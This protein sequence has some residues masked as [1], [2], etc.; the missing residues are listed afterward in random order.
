MGQDNEIRSREQINLELMHIYQRIGN[1]DAGILHSELDEIFQYK[2]VDNYFIFVK[3]SLFLYE[4]KY[5]KFWNTLSGKENW[6][7][8][9]PYAILLAKLQYEGAIATNSAYGARRQKINIYYTYLASTTTINTNRAIYLEKELIED[10]KECYEEEEGK[11]INLFRALIAQKNSKEQMIVALRKMFECYYNLQQDVQDVILL[12]LR[13]YYIADPSWVYQNFWNTVY[14]RESN[15]GY[16]IRELGEKDSSPF[17]VIQDK[18][19]REEEYHY[20][21]ECLRLLKQDVIIID[22]NFAEKVVQLLENH[23]IYNILASNDMFQNLK[24]RK[25]FDITNLSSFKG[26]L[27]GDLLSFGYCGKYEEYLHKIYKYRYIEKIKEE[28]NC[29]FSIV[30]PARNNAYTLKYTIQTILEQRNV[31]KDEFELVIS[32]NSDSGNNA[33]KNLVDSFDNPQIKYFRT[34]TELPLQRSFEFAYGMA[35]GKYI[36][37]VGSDDGF[38]PWSLETLKKM[39]KKYPD[40]NVIGWHRAFFQWSESKSNQSGKLIIPGIY[41]KEL[42][43]EKLYSGIATLKSQMKTNGKSIYAVP[44]LYINSAFK[45]KYL[46]EL[47]QNTGAVLDGYTQDIRMGIQSLLL[48]KTFLYLE[49]PLSIAGLSDASLGAKMVSEVKTD[50]DLTAK[51]NRE[52]VKGVGNVNISAEYPFLVLPST[53]GMFWSEI[54]KLLES[55]SCMEYLMELFTDHDFKETFLQLT[56]CRSRNDLDYIVTLEKI[57]CNAYWYSEEIG[58]WFDQLVYPAATGKTYKKSQKDSEKS[59]RTGYIEE[60]ELT[61]D[62]RRFGVYT[63]QDAVS[64]VDKILNL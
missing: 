11:K 4:K 52:R 29:L 43:N 9:G 56:S 10:A 36:I 26:P 38:F 33:I 14:N 30:I 1:V 18:K 63:I 20:L 61:L 7:F 3:A 35:K 40:E 47:W 58:R 49:Y 8:P 32:D 39:V 13:E 21:A 24:N 46:L 42:Y 57:R 37:S 6:Y 54:F 45:R 16:L 51:I 64:L 34:P 41:Q 62:G 55:D 31:S 12:K 27:F 22:C 53:E 60:K 50:E 59:Y 44:L 48:N 2:P 15:I 28:D 25:W 5:Q 19:E 23:P 17:L